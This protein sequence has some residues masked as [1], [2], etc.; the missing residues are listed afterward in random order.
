MPIGFAA[1]YEPVTRTL[2]PQDLPALLAQ[3]TESEQA[4][5]CYALATAGDLVDLERAKP[6]DYDP[7][8]GVVHMHGSKTKSRDAE[9]PVL[10]LFRDLFAFAHA[11]MPLEFPNASKR[12]P[13][14]AKRA[15]LGHLSP[16][17]LRRTACSWLIAAGADQDLVSRFM[18]HRDSKMVRLIYGQIRPEALGKL[19][20][21]QCSAG[22]SAT[23][24]G[25][26]LPC[27][28]APQKARP[29][30]LSGGTAGPFKSPAS[31][32]PPR[33]RA[34][35]VV[36]VC[37]DAAF[38]EETHSRAWQYRLAARFSSFPAR[39]HAGRALAE[40]VAAGAAVG[41]L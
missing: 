31:A 9:V 10:P 30:T 28:P 5:V 2:A 7:A 35:T 11:R 3:L 36:L 39:Y 14:R 37:G 4:W 13:E 20:A 24:P 16:K 18:R 1:G 23:A 22:M 21:A 17:D 27:L 29:S 38:C 40:L 19:L 8:R 34:S 6:E 41:C 15:G 26:V 12:L 25:A 32:V 33:G